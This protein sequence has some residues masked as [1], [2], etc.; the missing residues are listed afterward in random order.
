MFVRHF[1]VRA[2]VPLLVAVFGLPATAQNYSVTTFS[3]P[4]P[5]SVSTYAGG[6][7]DMGVIVGGYD[8]PQQ[9]GLFH[10]GFIR[11]ADGKLLYPIVDPNDVGGQDTV[12]WAVNSSG[13]IAGSY[14]SSADG[15][16][17]GFLLDNGNFTT[18]DEIENGDTFLYALNNNGDF[19]GAF[20][21]GPGAGTGF[22]SI[23]GQVTQVNV[24]GALTTTVTG[25][26]SD[27]SSVGNTDS[28]KQVFGFLRGPNGTIHT[29]QIPK[30]VYGTY[31]SAINS[32]L[33]L[34]VG[35]YYDSAGH[36][37]GFVYHYPHPL[38]ATGPD[39]TPSAGLVIELPDVITIDGSS[40]TGSTYP[41]G[42]NSSGVISGKWQGD[43]HRRNHAYAFIATP[44]Q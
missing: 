44:V 36:A 26:A 1:S 4:D 40:G 33:Q 28:G 39:S 38:D 5:P 21:P 9:F 14:L 35:Y 13:L 16:M 29:F 10:R 42:I 25:L 15:R 31:A 23:A 3:V 32:E 2:T 24:P 8:V 41:D 18:I 12:P 7:S 30:A 27:G 37:H 20:G 43:R 17:H 19:G 6:I 22:I 11:Q 34:V